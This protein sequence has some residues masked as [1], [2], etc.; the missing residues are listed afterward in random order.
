MTYTFFNQKV[1]NGLNEMY[2]EFDTIQWIVLKLYHKICVFNL[3]KISHL[4]DLGYDYKMYF[5]LE[6]AI[7]DLLGVY[8]AKCY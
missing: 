3:S 2:S 6:L 1:D 7:D 4:T 8:C 5:S